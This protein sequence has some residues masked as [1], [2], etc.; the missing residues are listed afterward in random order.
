MHQRLF[1]KLKGKFYDDLKLV[2]IMFYGVVFF[3]IIFMNEY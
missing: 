3:L 2:D 1:D